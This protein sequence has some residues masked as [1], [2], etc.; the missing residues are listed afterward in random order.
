MPA[1]MSSYGPARP[2][3]ASLLD[4][5]EYR[6]RLMAEGP[7]PLSVDGR[8]VGHGL[9]RRPIALPE[10]SAILMHPSCGFDTRDE[11]WRLLVARTRSEGAS[12]TVGAVGVAMPGLR[13]AAHRL[14]RTY[15]GDV[16]AA[17]VAEFVAAL[18]TVNVARPGVVSRLLDAASSAARS[19]LRAA[20]PAASGEANFAPGSTLPPPPSGHPDLVLV[21]AVVAGVLSA[22]DADLIGTIHLEDVSVAEYADRLGLSRW[23][24]YKR[25]RAA[26]ARLVEAIRSGALSDPDAEVIAA[27]TRTTAPDSSARRRP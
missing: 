3:G 22:E 18:A 17:L 27:A 8:K 7:K 2:A 4:E 23:T 6:F 21:R 26:E 13:N 12:W 9:P 25:R 19:A 24:V 10:L 16:H 15:T 20:E 11:V 1:R 14:S 5:I